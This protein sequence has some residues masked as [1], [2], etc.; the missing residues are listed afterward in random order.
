MKTVKIKTNP[1][2]LLT[3][4]YKDETRRKDIVPP[5]KTEKAYTTKYN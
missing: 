4:T 1:R 3:S 5:H 2:I